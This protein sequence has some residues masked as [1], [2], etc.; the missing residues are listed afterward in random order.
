MDFPQND[1]R[2]IGKIVKGMEYQISRRMQLMALSWYLYA[3][4]G[5][6]VGRYLENEKL[7]TDT[8]DTDEIALEQ[9][10][11]SSLFDSIL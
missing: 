9:V 3:S 6:L 11:I 7:N 2:Y 8:L 4:S 10:F 5:F 1:L